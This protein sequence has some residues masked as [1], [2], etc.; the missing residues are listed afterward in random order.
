MKFLTLS[1]QKLLEDVLQLTMLK[2]AKVKEVQ[3]AV[4][5]KEI[6]VI[7]QF[8]NLYLLSVF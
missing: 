3:R 4:I 8:H 1:F 5:V 7:Q 2:D 6:Y